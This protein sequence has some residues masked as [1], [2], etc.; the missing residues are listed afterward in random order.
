MKK[1]ILT[2]MLI[3]FVL[4]LDGCDMKHLTIEQ[5]QKN[6]LVYQ[7]AL[8]EIANE[9][10]LELIEKEDKSMENPDL[11][12]DLIITVS[13]S[14]NIEII[15]VNSAYKS[16]KGVEGFSIQYKISNLT[17]V[18][19]YD[20]PLFVSLVNSISGKKI[21]IDFCTEFLNAP[22]SKYSAEKYGYKK[23]NGEITA[24]QLPL[25][26]FEDWNISYVLSKENEGILTFGGLTKQ[27][28]G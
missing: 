25:N 24:K 10:D 18:N 7:G 19:D 8:Q 2:V 4:S 11:C 16:K 26:F 17:S 15:V 9:Y 5:S 27:L 20:I 21:S 13:P 22:E 12:R 6:F 28:A 14:S 1:L 3:S 23:L